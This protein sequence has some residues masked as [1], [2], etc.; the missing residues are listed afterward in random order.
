M[1]GAIAGDVIG[2]VH[3][4]EGTRTKD[5]PLFHEHCAFTDD[6]VLTVAIAEALLTGR[7]YVELF[8]E[9]FEDYPL[10]GYGGNFILW[11]GQKRT[12]PYNSWGNG[13]AMRVSPVGYAFDTLAEVLEEA[14]RSAAV[15][16]NHLE[17]I[18]GAKAVAGAVFLA[19][20]GKSKDD[21]RDF[22]TDAIGYTL[23]E[24]LDDIREDYRFDVSCQGSVPEAIQAFL[25][26]TDFED[27]I[28]NAVSLG[29]DAD[30]Q[31]CIAGAIAEPFFGGVP[32]EIAESVWEL[33]DERLQDITQSFR[34][35]FEIE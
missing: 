20:T 35:R 6:T 19:R 8:H 30:T 11:A 18:L 7:G 23:P 15:T 14:A 31:A 12:E 3:E 2:S 10:A 27:A 21:I 17:G 25:E 33:L 22:V 28:R 16:H 1:L 32:D 29:G 26:A 5:F 13:S 4:G 34:D 9:Y 24:S